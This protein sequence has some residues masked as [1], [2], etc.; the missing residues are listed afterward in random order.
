[1]GFIKLIKNYRTLGRK[2]FFARW[3]K[4]IERTSPSDQTNA[5]LQFTN[6]TLIGILCGF[7]VSVYYWR[8]T[9]WLAIILGAAF[10]NTFISRIALMQKKK[11][12][13]SFD[14]QLNQEEAQNETKD[15][16]NN[17]NNIH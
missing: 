2:E 12:I 15:M 4:G 5:Q 14:A 16:E 13:E 7:A 1:M 9:W 11:L 10:G 8:T 6:I 3:K 17:S